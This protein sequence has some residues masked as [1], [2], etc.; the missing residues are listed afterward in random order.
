V[1]VIITRRILPQMY[2]VC[3]RL[4]NAEVLPKPYVRFGDLPSTANCFKWISGFAY[5]RISGDVNQF[6]PAGH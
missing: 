5:A 2:R 3:K 4:V 1:C 6:E